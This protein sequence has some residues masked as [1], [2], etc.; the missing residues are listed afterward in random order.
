MDQ[1][2]PAISADLAFFADVAEKSLVGLAPKLERVETIL[3]AIASKIPKQAKDAMN[4][5]WLGHPVHPML[6]DIPVGAW[7]AAFFF[8]L[9]GAHDAADASVGLGVL[10][11]AP[12]ALAGI[13]DWADTIGEERKVGVVHA[14]S[15]LVATG[16]YA[17]SFIARKSGHRGSG[18]A[19]AMLGATCATVGGFLGG[20]L[21]YR[22]GAGV[23]RNAFE[24][25]PTDFTD[26]AAF[27]DLTE[28]KAKR[29]KVKG[30]P[31]MLLRKGHEV[32]AIGDRCPHRGGPLHKGTLDG[33]V[34][35]CPWHGSE[36]DVRTGGVVHGPSAAPALLFET[37]VEEGKVQIRARD[38]R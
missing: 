1:P 19:T 35:T 14:A 13:A 21:A 10:A 18:I 25:P 38:R 33:D 28:G 15:N 11:A 34:V 27:D 32:Y 20:V 23:D 16:L 7:S 9:V 37:R 26:A 24:E 5:T 36:F 31:V 4:G 30:I 2:A 12:T 6:T 8:D 3:D 22:K 17:T 29:V